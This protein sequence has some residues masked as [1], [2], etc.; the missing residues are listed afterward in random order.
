MYNSALTKVETDKDFEDVMTVLRK[1]SSVAMECF[2]DG[3]DP[4]AKEVRAV[5]FSFDGKEGFYCLMESN[6][7]EQ[8]LM[9]SFGRKNIEIYSSQ[10][11]EIISHLMR[12]KKSFEARRFDVIQAH[13]V[14]NPDAN[15]N[16]NAI[17]RIYLDIDFQELEEEQRELQ[18]ACAVHLL[19]KKLKEELKTKEVEHVYYDIDNALVPVLARME[20]AGVMINKEYFLDLEEELDK[21][22]LAIEKK[23]EAH[24]GG[25][26]IN[27]NSLQ[28]S[29]PHFFLK[30]LEC[31]LSR[32]P[33]PGSLL[34]SRF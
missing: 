26:S 6:R 27:L 1:K 15:S 12:T 14:A 31:P 4:F 10:W 19:A 8:L 3:D 29:V 32:R 34:M 7:W 5:S 23:I 9:A 2:F 20:M 33:K 24:S 18:R 30:S 11:Q 17:M 16:F 21:K 22:I 13:Y 28:T 25:A